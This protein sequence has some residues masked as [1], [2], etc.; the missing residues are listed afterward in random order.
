[1]K[2][3]YLLVIEYVFLLIMASPEGLCRMNESKVVLD[4]GSEGIRHQRDWSE[5]SIRAKN[6]LRF[7]PWAS[8]VSGLPSNITLDSCIQ[9]NHSKSVDP[10]FQI[11]SIQLA[12]KYQERDKIWLN[13]S[14]GNCEELKQNSYFHWEPPHLN[15]FFAN[16]A[17]KSH[18]FQHS[19][20]GPLN[21]RCPWMASPR[22][23]ETKKLFQWVDW[24]WR[25]PW[26]NHFR[27]SCIAN[28]VALLNCLEPIGRDSRGVSQKNR[29]KT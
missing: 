23:P 16:V 24:G 4:G 12:R 13:I 14:W 1:M 20:L 10:V 27:Y 21:L 5:G 22:Q 15:P 19:S 2:F 28:A 18:H 29:I 26:I 6:W 9:P 7:T 17:T 3:D 11:W 8:I 25:F